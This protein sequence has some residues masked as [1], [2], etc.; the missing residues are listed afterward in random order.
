MHHRKFQL[1]WQEFRFDGTFGKQD[2]N[3][4]IDLMGQQLI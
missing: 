4:F 1:I 2:H 3:F